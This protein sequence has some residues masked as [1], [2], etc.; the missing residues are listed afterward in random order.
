MILQILPIVMKKTMKND[1]MST[2]KEL[3]PDRARQFELIQKYGDDL[4]TA[5]EMI[6]MLQLAQLLFRSDDGLGQE[7]ANCFIAASDKKLADLRG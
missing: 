4:I 7:A 3:S 5:D 2:D 1:H 6:E